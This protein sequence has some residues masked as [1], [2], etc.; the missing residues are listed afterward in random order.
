MLSLV[1]ESELPWANFCMQVY[2]DAVMDEAPLQILADTCQ[3][4]C[5]SL[6]KR[7]ECNAAGITTA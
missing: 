1:V 3:L 5:D 6:L 4:P 7:S 2:G